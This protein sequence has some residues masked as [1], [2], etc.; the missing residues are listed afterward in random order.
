MGAIMLSAM[1][2]LIAAQLRAL[3]ALLAA[4]SFRGWDIHELPDDDEFL[5]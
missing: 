5:D 3:A 2:E 1:R 4:T